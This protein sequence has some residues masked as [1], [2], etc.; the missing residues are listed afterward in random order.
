MVYPTFLI[1]DKYQKFKV[2]VS[3]TIRHNQTK[4]QKVND[5]DFCLYQ[6][7]PTSRILEPSPHG[8]ISSTEIYVCTLNNSHYD[9]KECGS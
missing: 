9:V 2:R 1:F 3:H 6:N 7:A 4:W 8:L 5:F